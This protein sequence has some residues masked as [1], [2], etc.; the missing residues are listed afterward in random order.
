M[1]RRRGFTLIELLV[2]IAIIA[3]LAAILFP[4]FARARERARTT[5]CQ[6]NIRQLGVAFAMYRADYDGI[7]PENWYLAEDN[8]VYRWIHVTYGYIF[9]EDVYQCPS[10][11]A[12]GEVAWTPPYTTSRPFSSYY[13]AHYYLAGMSESEVL[14]TTETVM[15]MDG[16]FFPNETIEWNAG[17]FRSPDANANVMAAWCNGDGDAPYVNDTIVRQIRRHNNGVNFAHYDG[18]VKWAGRA[19]PRDFLPRD[20]IY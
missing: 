14:R 20:D 9:N 2:V 6:N 3:I 19:A 13:Y 15:L 17:M 7:M 18:H 4:V 16:W 12:T 5:S 11:P 8:R 10:R 1:M